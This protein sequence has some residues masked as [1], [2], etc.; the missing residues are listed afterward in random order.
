[1][2]LSVHQL[3][4]F[5]GFNHHSRSWFF[6]PFSRLRFFGCLSKVFV[7]SSKA[8]SFVASWRIL[9]TKSSASHS[10][11]RSVNLISL[12][13][14]G[15]FSTATCV[16]LICL[17]G[18]SGAFSVGSCLRLVCVSSR[19]DEPSRVHPWVCFSSCFHL[20]VA[21]FGVVSGQPHFFGLMVRTGGTNQISHCATPVQDFFHSTRDAMVDLK[22]SI[23]IVTQAT[24]KPSYAATTK[25]A[26]YF[27][28]VGG[29]E[30]TNPYSSRTRATS[31]NRGSSPPCVWYA[32]LLR[33]YFGRR[34][35]N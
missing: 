25:P 2:A 23:I 31:W 4:S 8:S 20:F 15:G 1:M 29:R 5:L 30:C 10:C 22:Q 24:F 26:Q 34:A 19:C 35:L 16:R 32:L 14:V 28:M 3:L 27:G 12:C 11:L 33:E 13:P 17:A 6:Y 18:V 7:G 21:F 9:R